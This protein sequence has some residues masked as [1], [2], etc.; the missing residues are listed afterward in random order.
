MSEQKSLRVELVSLDT[1]TVSHAPYLSG[2]GEDAK[3]VN[4]EGKV[5]NILI[6]KDGEAAIGIR[7]LE[8][9]SLIITGY[10]TMF[11]LNMSRNVV[12]ENDRPW[13]D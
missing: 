13:K 1:P 11:H 6:K 8:N 12:L 3:Q 4:V 2:W 10:T 9:G 7:I 5:A